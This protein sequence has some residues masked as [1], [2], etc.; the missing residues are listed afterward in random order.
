MPLPFCRQDSRQ[1]HPESPID[2]PRTTQNARCLTERLVTRR[3]SRD[4]GNR[5]GGSLKYRPDNFLA[6]SRCVS[7]KNQ[8][9]SFESTGSTII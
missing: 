6:L 4:K 2:Y 7:P 9:A 3:P 8:D 1:W 5:N